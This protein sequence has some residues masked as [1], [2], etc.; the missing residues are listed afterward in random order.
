MPTPTV[1]C[2]WCHLPSNEQEECEDC[3]AVLQRL[4]R[5]LKSEDARKHVY[6]L[7]ITEAEKA[8]Y[9]TMTLIAGTPC[10]ECG[11]PGCECYK[12]PDGLGD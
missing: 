6:K 3:Q 11:M 7:L 5:F 12:I 9:R 4:D 8:A 10:V 1:Y 2:K